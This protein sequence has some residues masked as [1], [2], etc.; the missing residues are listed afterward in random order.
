MTEEE[1]RPVSGLAGACILLAACGYHS[2]YAAGSPARLHVKVV[3][4]LVADAVAADEVAS[5]V[6]EELARAGA[7]AGGDGYPR[8]EIE[9]LRADETSEGITAGAS[10][11]VARGTGVAVVARAWVTAED[12]AAPQEDTGDVRAEESIT[13]DELESETGSA[14][15]GGGAGEPDPRASAFH[16]A[17]ASRAAARRLG[18]KLGARVLGE[19]A[20]S[21][22]TGS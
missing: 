10:G 3:R 4:S 7:L 9:V 13:V 8:V 1:R 2:I 19:P 20:A 5:G 22:D 14:G 18:R 11:P 12:G 21:E 17:D 15:G 6:R 16:H